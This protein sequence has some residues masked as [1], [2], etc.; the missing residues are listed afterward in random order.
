[1][2]TIEIPAGVNGRLRLSYRPWWLVWGGGVS[3]LC[4]AL[5]TIGS[6]LA[7]REKKLNQS[8]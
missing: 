2:P 3:L 8:Q 4:A 6:V 7:V 5:F 1:M